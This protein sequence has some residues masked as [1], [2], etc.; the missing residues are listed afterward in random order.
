[1]SV[2]ARIEIPQF[3]DDK[4]FAFTTSWDDGAIADR[5]V[6]QSFNEWGIKGTFNLNSSKLGQPHGICGSHVSPD[7]VAKLYA[8]HEVA[9]HTVTHP[10]LEKLEPSQIAYEVLEDRRRLEDLVGYPVRGMAYPFGTY[11][12]KVIQILRDLGIVYSR[13]VE[14]KWNPWPATEPLAW[15]ATCHKFNTDEGGPYA[16][17]TKWAENWRTSGL[18]YIW[19]HSYEFEQQ[20]CWEK[21]EQVFKPF[22]GRTDMWYCT[23]I[24]LFDYEAARQRLVIGAN[25]AVAYNPSAIPVTIKADGK[26]IVIP[27]GATV[28][29]DV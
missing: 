9:I 8:G 13:T 5:R 7:E 3:P 23:N 28:K 21:L 19:G 26:V 17:F 4:R 14:N 11:N 6:I 22:A 2:P 12:Q 29:I 27:A 18:V 1:M 16:R 20:K 24:Q 10:W 15:A 25:R